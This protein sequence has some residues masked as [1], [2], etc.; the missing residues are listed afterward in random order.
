M[1]VASIALSEDRFIFFFSPQRTQRAQRK[2]QTLP[3]M[4]ADDTD[5]SDPIG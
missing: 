3:L 2:S 4:N 5:L 1:R